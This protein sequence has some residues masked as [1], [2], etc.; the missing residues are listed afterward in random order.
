M[1]L[2]GEPEALVVAGTISSQVSNVL[3]S[4]SVVLLC[5]QHWVSWVKLKTEFPPW[6]EIGLLLLLSTVSA[7]HILKKT[8]RLDIF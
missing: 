5:G 7:I 3:N 8:W 4:P 2:P 1:S 6:E